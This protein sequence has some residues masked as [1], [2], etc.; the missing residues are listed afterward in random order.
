MLSSSNFM[1]GIHFCSGEIQNIG[2]LTEAEACEKEQSTP[3]CHRHTTTPCCED[4]T[5]L[6]HSD[7][8]KSSL[9]HVHAAAPLAMDMVD[10]EVLVS[11]VIPESPASR[12]PYFLYD[13]PGPS[14]DITITNQVLLI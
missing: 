4:E 13:P 10:F 14:L 8:L 1:V 5:I 3:P 6:H 7:E 9:S 2:F 12:T 11:E